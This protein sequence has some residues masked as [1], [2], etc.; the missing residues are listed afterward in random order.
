M[1]IFIYKTLFV[2]FCIF[3]LF[4]FTIGNKIQNIEK[5][6]SETFNEQGREDVKNK[7]RKE[8]SKSI[9]K[10]QI[11]YPE[12]RELLRKFIIKLKDEL[13]L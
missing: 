10:D 6:I 4:Q 2:F 12:D 11:L 3:L 5:Q 9:S 13:N 7:I 1:K 8:L